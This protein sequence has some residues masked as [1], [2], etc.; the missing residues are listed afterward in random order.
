MGKPAQSQRAAMRLD[1]I[2]KNEAPGVFY[3]DCIN[4]AVVI[5]V[6]VS[7]DFYESIPDFV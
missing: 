6:G 1:V 2:E 4:T 3:S 7:F 5:N